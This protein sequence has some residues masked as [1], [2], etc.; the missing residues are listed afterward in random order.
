MSNEAT[1]SRGTSRRS[2]WLSVTPMIPAGP[3]LEAAI[4]FYVKR[5]GFSVVWQSGN[6][7]GIR[8]GDVAF[9]LVVNDSR[10]WAENSSYSIA[11]D[12]LD[13]LYAEFRDLPANVGPLEMKFWGRREFHMIVPSGVC[14]QFYEEPRA[15]G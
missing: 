10:E 2:R 4:D 13:A 14:L 8:R 12:D 9:N 7:A 11:V 6:S 5:M 15:R 1:E 3:S